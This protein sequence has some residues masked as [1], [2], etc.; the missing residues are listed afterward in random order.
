[1]KAV[2]AKWIEHWNLYKK[3]LRFEDLKLP[4]HQEKMTKK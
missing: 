4:L 2:V 3:D 1:M